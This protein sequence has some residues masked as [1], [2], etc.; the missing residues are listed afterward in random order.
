MTPEEFNEL[1]E[2]IDQHETDLRGQ[3]TE[4]VSL[5]QRMAEHAREIMALRDGLSKLRGD[6]RDGL[7]VLLKDSQ[8]ELEAVRRILQDI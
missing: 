5:R 3:L 1:K 6:I 4:M 7:E 2:K 8:K